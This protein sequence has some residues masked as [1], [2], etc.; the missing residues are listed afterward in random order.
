MS[1]IPVLPIQ[2][3]PQ[4]ILPGYEVSPS[5][6]ELMALDLSFCRQQWSQTYTCVDFNSIAIYTI[7]CNMPDIYLV[8]MGAIKIIAIPPAV[9]YDAF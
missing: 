8:K 4:Q 7:L 3:G 6:S 1:F 2:L 9:K 5:Q